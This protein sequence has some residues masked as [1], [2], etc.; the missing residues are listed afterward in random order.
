MLWNRYVTL[1]CMANGSRTNINTDP[2]FWRASWLLEFS[3]KNSYKWKPQL[4]SY[5][6]INYT[7][8]VNISCMNELV[9]KM[10]KEQNR[11]WLKKTL[12]GKKKTWPL[13]KDSVSVTIK[14]IKILQ[15][16]LS[17]TTYYFLRLK[18]IDITH[19]WGNINFVL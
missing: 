15:N 13:S 17:L 6:M 14:Q 7:F 19:S 11:K 9:N 5:I 10:I 4:E 2:C 3:I 16:L 12:Y 18:K 8:S 1:C